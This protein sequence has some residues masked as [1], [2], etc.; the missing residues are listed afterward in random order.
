MFL[1]LIVYYVSSSCH[2]H[3]SALKTMT[4]LANLAAKVQ[5]LVDDQAAV[6]A[7]VAEVREEVS[8]VRQKVEVLYE[9]HEKTTREKAEGCVV[10]SGKGIPPRDKKSKEG[11]FKIVQE[12]AMNMF[13]IKI[14][15]E[16]LVSC[17]RK[18]R[19]V[20]SP[21]IARY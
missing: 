12:M 17:S 4:T 13:K 18:G 2:H 5:Q 21:I 8:E 11:P 1:D 14:R 9:N 10:I 3:L 16:D 19:H 6:K 7:E 15:A 20:H